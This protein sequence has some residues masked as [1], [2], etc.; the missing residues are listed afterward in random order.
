M[1]FPN[2][3]TQSN[4][5]NSIGMVLSKFYTELIGAEGTRLLLRSEFRGDPAGASTPR[6]LRDRPRKA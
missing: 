5:F 2:Q 3:L 4:T 1:N 6:R